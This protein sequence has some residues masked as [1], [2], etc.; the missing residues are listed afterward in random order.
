MVYAV[1]TFAFGSDVGQN[2]FEA[3]QRY[4]ERLEQEPQS[5]VVHTSLAEK[6]RAFLAEKEITI[7]I[8]GRWGC[9][10][11]EVWLEV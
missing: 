10:S 9:L 11:W 2:I 6:A 8:E 1:F 5:I 3:L 7:D 4:G